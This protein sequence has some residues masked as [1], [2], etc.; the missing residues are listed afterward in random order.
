MARNTAL[1]FPGGL[2]G[3]NHGDIGRLDDGRMSLQRLGE[4]VACG[5]RRAK[6][7]GESRH[8]LAGVVAERLQ[9]AFERQPGANE[10]R[11]LAQK[12]GDIARSW[13]LPAAPTGREDSLRHRLGVDRQM[14]EIFDAPD[15]LLARGRIDFANDDLSCLRQSAIAELWHLTR[16]QTCRNAKDLIDSRQPG[17][18][19]WPRH[20]RSSWSCPR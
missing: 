7:I 14:A 4:A 1:Q 19:S 15:D 9:R 11:E 17:P 3:T 8:R 18:A 6:R 12:D 20:R 2:A 16:L 10:Q 5:D 13:Q